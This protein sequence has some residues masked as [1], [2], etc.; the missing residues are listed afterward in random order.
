MAIYLVTIALTTFLAWLYENVMKKQKKVVFAVMV[1]IPT[2]V[3]GLRGVGTDYHLY[4]ERFETMQNDTFNVTERNLLYII[5]QLFTKIG[6]NYQLFIF[7]ISFAT[8]LIAFYLIVQ[9]ENEI[10]LKFSVLAY[11][12]TFFQMSFN[13]YRQIL[14]SELFLL[15]IF[16]LVNKKNKRSF[17][18]TFVIAAAI[19]TALIPFVLI[20]FMIPLSQQKRYFNKRMAVYILL[21]VMVITLPLMSEFLVRLAKS[22]SHYTFYLIN[23]SYSGIGVGFFRYIIL[24]VLPAILIYKYRSK[25]DNLAVLNEMRTYSFLSVIGTILWMTS[26][27]STTYLY[28]AG[29]ICLIVLPIIHGYIVKR[30]ERDKF[31]FFVSASVAAALLFFW[32]YDCVVLNSGDTYPYQFFWQIS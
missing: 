18:I 20:Y 14:G 12:L 24:A 19:H 26:Y 21:S 2:I 4:N 32:W 28:R 27:V 1:I 31:N 30:L 11:M 16:F 13:I 23:F 25:G 5:M 17:W 6:L 10:N 29:Y 7:L 22:I 15:A 9:Y 8:I 3:S